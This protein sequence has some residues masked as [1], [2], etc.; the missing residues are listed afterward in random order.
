MNDSIWSFFSVQVAWRP[1]QNTIGSR[2]RPVGFTG[3]RTVIAVAL[4]S[5]FVTG[6]PY[7][8]A[9]ASVHQRVAGAEEAAHDRPGGDA[10][11]LGRLLVGEAEEVDG[12][13]RV[14]LV[15]GQ[16]G[17][18]G[19]ELAGLERALGVGEGV[20][21]VAL[22]ILGR[23]GRGGAAGRRAALGDEGVAQ[24]AQEVAEVVVAADQARLGEHAHAHVLDE[25]LGV[26]GGA[27]Q[28]E[29]GAGEGGGGGGPE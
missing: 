18:A 7:R 6:R 28:A 17:D 12:P 13:E 14:A 29:S 16:I 4:P 27:G 11:R 23:G 22:E 9:R 26:G 8:S 10:Q 3:V 1:T 5:T 25:V 21:L 20:G 15:F 24:D 19:V 2:S